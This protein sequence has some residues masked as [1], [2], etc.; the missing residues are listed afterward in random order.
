MKF[1]DISKCL[2]IITAFMFK[3]R[4]NAMSQLKIRLKE[5]SNKS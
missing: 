5:Y 2:K 1:V 4:Y 3:F